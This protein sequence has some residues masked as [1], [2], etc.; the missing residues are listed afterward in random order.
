[1]MLQM[2]GGSK[3]IRFAD[4]VGFKVL[5]AAFLIMLIMLCVRS[6]SAPM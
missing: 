1:M 4:S 2:G 6:R 5:V 3:L